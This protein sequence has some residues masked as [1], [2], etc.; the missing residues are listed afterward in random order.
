M[1]TKTIED[2]KKELEKID[3]KKKKFQKKEEKVEEKKENVEEKVE[4]KKEENTNV[5]NKYIKNIII[6][7]IVNYD[8]LLKY[9]IMGVLRKI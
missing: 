9:L 5:E 2:K 1:V 8:N 7:I 4:E 3:E 6:V